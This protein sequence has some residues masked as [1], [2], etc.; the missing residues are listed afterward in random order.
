MFTKLYVKS[1]LIQAF[2]NMR[3]MQC[4]GFRLLTDGEW[5]FTINTNPYMANILYGAGRGK[6]TER[7]KLLASVCAMYGD[8][9]FWN[10]L[11]PA[12]LIISLAGLITGMYAVTAAAFL[13]Y[14]IIINA[15]RIYGF[16]YGAKHER[17]YLLFK[18]RPF[19]II[20][21]V[22]RKLK[23]ILF[24]T[25]IVYIA[26]LLLQYL[27]SEGIYVILPILIILLLTY[28]KENYILYLTYGVLM[29]V[30]ILGR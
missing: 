29:I 20:V 26:Y 16:R 25:S 19:L 9:L 7:I 2:I 28:K 1:L 11:K 24:G 30:S 8:N 6:E 27:K 21:Q 15:F 18:E 13:L 23:L 4:R 12:V 14:N 22:S 17:D 10:L 5:D 3:S